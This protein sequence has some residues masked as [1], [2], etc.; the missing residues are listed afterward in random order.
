[1]GPDVGLEVRTRRPLLM[2]EGESERVT[3][4][5]LYVRE[6]RRRGPRILRARGGI[7]LGPAAEAGRDERAADTSSVVIGRGEGGGRGGRG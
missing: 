2:V 4:W 6:G 3:C 1:M 7:P 5:I